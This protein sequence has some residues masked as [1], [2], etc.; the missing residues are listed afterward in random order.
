MET[1]QSLYRLGYGLYG[2]GLVSWQ[3]QEILFS[4][5][6]I[7]ILGPN[8]HTGLGFKRLHRS[9]VQMFTPV[10]GP[11]VYTGLGSRRSHRPWVQT[12]TPVLG[13]NVHTGLRS[14]PAFYSMGTAI[15]SQG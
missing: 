10:L 2:P 7:P 5:T 9:W 12:F 3:G 4:E 6:F 14:H 15:L 8:V 13:P 11:N 1:A